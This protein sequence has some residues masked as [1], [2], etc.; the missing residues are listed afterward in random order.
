MRIQSVEAFVV[1]AEI[2]SAK[3]HF[4]DHGHVSTF[5]TVIAV[6]RTES[7]VTGYGEAKVEGASI[8]SVLAHVNDSIAPRLKGQSVN[9]VTRLWELMFAGPRAAHALNRGHA[10]PPVMRRG[11]TVSA[12]AAVDLALWDAKGKTL[13]LPVWQLLGGKVRDRIP[14]YGS[15]GWAPANAI[16][17]E[18]Q[19][20]V[21]SGGFKIVKMRVGAGDGSVNTSIERVHAA[22]DVLEPNV[23]VAVDAHGTLT[24]AEAKKV[25]AALESCD[26]AWFEEPV[27]PD[28]KRDLAEVRKFSTIPIAAGERETTRFDAH[29]LLQLNAVDILQPDLGICGGLTEGLR[30]AAMASAY[31]IPVMPH[32]WGSGVLLGA[33]LAYCAATPSAYMIEYCMGG[34]PLL[35][36]LCC[37]PIRVMDGFVDI[38][39]GPGFGIEVDKDYLARHRV[40]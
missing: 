28:N 1:R 34:N 39:E 14:A 21:D 30:I 27:S 9:D 22:R 25:S 19:S 6:A 11:A 26:L 3:R 36:S 24:L 13:G 2:P 10:F 40:A 7:G 5:E 37:E 29:E 20:Y 12:I 35:E 38:L 15:G 32:V 31:D 8:Q 33:T 18:L 16:G 4:T 23:K 17:K